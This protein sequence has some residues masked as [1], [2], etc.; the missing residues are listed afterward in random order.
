MR[1]P[2]HLSCRRRR[3]RCRR[4]R[5]EVCSV[6]RRRRTNVEDCSKAQLERN[7]VDGVALVRDH[8]A[9][10]AMAQQ[11][12][13]AGKSGACK[14]RTL[15]VAAQHFAT[16]DQCVASTDAHG[17]SERIHLHLAARFRRNRR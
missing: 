1:A 14:C 7:C 9:S 12:Q 15:R 11:G 8:L 17:Q 4:H 5:P 16:A 2:P 6:W 3:E 10:A 13:C